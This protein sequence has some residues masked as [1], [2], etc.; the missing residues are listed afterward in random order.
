M[1]VVSPSELAV[2]VGDRATFHCEAEGDGE[3]TVEWRMG[4]GSPLPD[5]VTQERVNLVISNADTSLAGSYVCA[6]RNLADEVEATAELH[7]FCE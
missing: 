3:F 4:D 5:G 6:V 2:N 7:V 1:A